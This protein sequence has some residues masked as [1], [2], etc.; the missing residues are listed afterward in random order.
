L[1][2]SSL[3]DFS[4]CSHSD[5]LW[6]LKGWS[7][8]NLKQLD[9]ASF[10]FLKVKENKAILNKSKFFAAYCYAHIGK[11]DSA[12]TVINSISP[13]SNDEKE[14]ITTQLSGFSLLNRNLSSFNLFSKNFSESHFGLVENQRTLKSLYTDLDEF[15]LKSPLIAGLLSAAVPGLGKVYAGK[16]GSGLSS[17]LTVGIAGVMTYENYAKN[18]LNNPKTIIF[19][20]LFS[21][22]YVANIYGSVF[23]IKAYRDEFNQQIDY[24]ILFHLHIPIRNLYN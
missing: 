16:L 4:G 18:G 2:H 9:S 23:S 15:K 11:L 14:L 19:G 3:I 8:Y 1:L 17:F 10:S 5:S 13:I 6:F 12:F 22:L 21:I 7:Q 24:R 20:S